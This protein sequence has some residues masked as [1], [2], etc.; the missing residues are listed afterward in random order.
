MVHL[1]FAVTETATSTAITVTAAAAATIIVIDL[2]MK[3]TIKRSLIY[4]C[5]DD[6]EKCIILSLNVSS[7]ACGLLS[8]M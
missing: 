8:A 1:M 4:V 6:V 3:N 7:E 5:A 2:N